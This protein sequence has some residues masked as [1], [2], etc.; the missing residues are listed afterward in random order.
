MRL[1]KTSGSIGLGVFFIVIGLLMTGLLSFIFYLNIDMSNR[2]G[3]SFSTT[4]DTMTTIMPIFLSLMTLI[5]FFMGIRSIVRG[6]I[7]K[8]VK[9]HGK[10][11]VCTIKEFKVT[12]NRYSATIWMDV[13]FKTQ[14]GKEDIYSA[15]VHQDAINRFQQGM[16]FE[17]YVLGE[18]CY[19]D[20]NNLRVVEKEDF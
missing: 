4:A 13:K 6:L 9:A 12:S 5:V 18:N 15:R 1:G 10:K 17:C 19:V 2:D 3:G 11:S 8:K 20:P 16:K 14:S 7:D